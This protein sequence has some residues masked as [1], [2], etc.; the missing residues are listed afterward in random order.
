MPR[1]ITCMTGILRGGPDAFPAVRVTRRT[2][3]AARAAPS[4]SL[5]SAV[6]ARRASRARQRRPG[7]PEEPDPEDRQR[8]PDGDDHHRVEDAAL[9]GGAALAAHRAHPRRLLRAVIARARV[10]LV[11]PVEVA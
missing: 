6:R 1:T 9:A 10:G 3:T 7:E 2:A 5:P 11:D 4:P 8:E